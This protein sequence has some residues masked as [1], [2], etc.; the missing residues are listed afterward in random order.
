M[1]NI[2][3]SAQQKK[4]K[5]AAADKLN[6][7]GIG[8][9]GRGGA[10]I[11][12]LS[13]ENIVALC[14]VDWKYAANQFAA[15]PDAK[16]YKDFR[17]L[18][19]EMGNKIDAIVV[20]TA[21]HTHAVIAAQALAM[22]KHVYCEKPLTHT[23]YETRLLT[24]LAA[25]HNVATQNGEPGCFGRGCPPDMRSHLE[26]NDWRGCQG[27]SLYRQTYL[28]PG[29]GNSHMQSILHIPSWTGT[30]L[31]ARPNTVPTMK[32]TIRGIGAAG[33]IS[34]PGP[35]R[36]G[37]PYSPT[38]CKSAKSE[39]SRCRAGKFHCFDDDCA[40]NARLPNLFPSRD[41]MP[42]VA[43]PRVEVTWYDGGLLPE[44]PQGWPAAAI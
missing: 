41:N 9:G 35:R 1:A 23:V 4:K 36:Y 21:D 25:R 24:R 18:F 40:P 27:G 22:G 13:S 38:R 6:I 12:E 37:L 33:G 3:F 5:T 17:K 14:D 19:D 44:Y 31:S 42:K 8:I 15:Y 30:F 29:P 7:A 43:M 16:K 2:P 28:A 39:I 10:V 11:R 20:G 34:V 26:R 32:F